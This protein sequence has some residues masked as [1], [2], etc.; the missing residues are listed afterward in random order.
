MLSMQYTRKPGK[1]WGDFAHVETELLAFIEEHG[2]PGVMPSRNDLRQAGLHDLN[3]ALKRHGGTSAVAKRLNL[4]PKI[5]PMGHW[6][7]FTNIEKTL[8]SYIDEYGTLG[9]M[10]TA[11]ELQKAG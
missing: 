3:G 5:K 6:D 11:S 8:S 4:Q 1:Y 7:D 9:V 2:T 10:P